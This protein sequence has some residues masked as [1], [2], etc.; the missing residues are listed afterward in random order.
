MNQTIER[1]SYDGTARVW[2]LSTGTTL[3][4]LTSHTSAV[5]AVAC[6]V[7]DGRP[8]TITT[9]GYHTIRTWDLVSGAEVMV[10][11][12]TA[13]LSALVIGPGQEIVIGEG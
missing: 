9:S 13:P 10:H 2:D 7:V 12:F 5:V 4:T 6:T 11:H 3:H 1:S 8:V